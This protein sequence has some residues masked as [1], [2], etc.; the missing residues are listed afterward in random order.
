VSRGR[1]EN[2]G[3]SLGTRQG[4]LESE[5][6]L[7]GA[8]DKTDNTPRTATPCRGGERWSSSQLL[9]EDGILAGNRAVDK[10]RVTRPLGAVDSK[11]VE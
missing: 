1:D 5:Q 11:A 3:V 2:L 7:H 9:L 10:G 4:I 8:I 6:D